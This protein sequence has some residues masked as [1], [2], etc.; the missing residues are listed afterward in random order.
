LVCCGYMNFFATW[1]AAM[2]WAGSHPE[3]TGGI[4]DQGRARPASRH[5]HLRAATQLAPRASNLGS[6]AAKQTRHRLVRPVSLDGCDTTADVSQRRP[7][8]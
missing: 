3:I 1:A 6:M 2:A 4:L 8:R 7:A 5:R